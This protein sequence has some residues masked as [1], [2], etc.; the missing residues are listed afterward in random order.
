MIQTQIVIRQ[1]QKILR[2]VA[3]V[4]LKNGLE[5]SPRHKSRATWPFPSPCPKFPRSFHPGSL[6]RLGLWKMNQVIN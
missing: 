4:G 3:R 6:H 1:V 5:K 2:K